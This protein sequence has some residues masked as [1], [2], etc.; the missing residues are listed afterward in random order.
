MPPDGARALSS[1]SFAMS[2]WGTTSSV[3]TLMERRVLTAS[4]TVWAFIALRTSI[5][6]GSN[7][8]AILNTAVCRMLS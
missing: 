7:L 1:S 2:C 5:F 3:K 6:R 8:S 4:V